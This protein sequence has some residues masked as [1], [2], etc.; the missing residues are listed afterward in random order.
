M[1]ETVALKYYK[2]PGDLV[3]LFRALVALAKDLVS[4]SSHYTQ[5]VAHHL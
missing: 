5:I 3:Q 2:E 1:R 4:S